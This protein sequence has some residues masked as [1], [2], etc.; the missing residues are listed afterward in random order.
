MLY[1]RCLSSTGTLCL[2]I[3]FVRRCFVPIRFV[4]LYVFVSKMF[5]RRCLLSLIHLDWYV[6]SRYI[7]SMYE[8]A[9]LSEHTRCGILAVSGSV[10]VGVVFGMLLWLKIPLLLLPKELLLRLPSLW[11][12]VKYIKKYRCQRWFVVVEIYMLYRTSWYLYIV[13]R[14]MLGYM[15]LLTA[16]IIC[17][18]Q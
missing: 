9:C 7:L 1:C 13:F 16:Y 14:G 17:D 15:V 2:L 4:C 6:S 8:N 11:L 12:L 5:C 18:V 10:A 3:R